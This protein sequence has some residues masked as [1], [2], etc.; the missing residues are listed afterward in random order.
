[1][2]NPEIHTHIVGTASPT[3]VLQ[4]IAD[5]AAPLD[6]SLLDEVLAILEPVHNLT[7]PSGRPENNRA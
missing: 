6:Q 3:R 5:A 7:W 1:M 2:A 4:N